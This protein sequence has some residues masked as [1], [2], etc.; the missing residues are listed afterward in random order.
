[1][2]RTATAFPK[3][4]YVNPTVNLVSQR[5]LGIETGSPIKIQLGL[6][7]RHRIVKRGYLLAVP[8]G[9]TLLIHILV[10]AHRCFFL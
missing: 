1:V 10:V 8:T 6:P 7:P 4:T 3:A 2:T 9:D 5:G